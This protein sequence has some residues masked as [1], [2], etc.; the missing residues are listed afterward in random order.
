MVGVV[1]GVA[2]LA[3]DVAERG[4]STA[5]AVLQDARV[6]LKA[7]FDHGI[8]LAEKTSAAFFRFAKKLGQRLDEG[9]AETLGKTERLLSGAVHSARNTTNAA[10]DLAHSATHGLAGT[11]TAQA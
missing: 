8:E 1:P 4:Q 3:L 7:V 11:P 10:T 2:H 9:V 6:E 5:I